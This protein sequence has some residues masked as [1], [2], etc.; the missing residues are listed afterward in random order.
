M[1]W[2]RYAAR[3]RYTYATPATRLPP[4]AR[5]HLTTL[6]SFPWFPFC[7]AY[8]AA[9]HHHRYT[10][11][12]DCISPALPHVWLR[13]P[14]VCCVSSRCGSAFYFCVRPTTPRLH[15]QHLLCPYAWFM[16]FCQHS[17]Y[18]VPFNDIAPHIR[19]L[20]PRH[21]AR[22]TTL[23]HCRNDILLQASLHSLP[24]TI[25]VVVHYLLSICNLPHFTPS[26]DPA[27]L[28]HTAT[29]ARTCPLLLPRFVRHRG[30]LCPWHSLCVPGRAGCGI[31][32]VQR[33]LS[34]SSVTVR[35]TL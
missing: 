13:L 22:H 20:P 35:Y 29:C 32:A 27:I 5:C 1:H 34:A 8:Y 24:P 21:T 11:M 2:P 3:T 12:P 33:R 26:R 30:A 15:I 18:I 6:H 16:P 10:A 25:W 28:P 19:F 31:H 23:S 7:L 14:P 17:V 9:L 4:P